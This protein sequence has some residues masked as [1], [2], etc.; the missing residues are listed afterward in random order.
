V[1]T[2]PERHT[3]TFAKRGRERKI[4]L[5]YLRNNRTNTSIC[6]FSTR[7]RPGAPVSMPLDWDELASEPD[8]YTMLTAPRRLKRLRRDP[9][10]GSWT[11]AQAVTGDA[12]AALR[13][14]T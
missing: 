6:A 7:A 9:W 3:I 1:R 10:A 2:D 13:Q 14:L 12:L 11:S 5:D 8:R 4:L